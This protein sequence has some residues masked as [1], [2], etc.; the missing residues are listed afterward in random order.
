MLQDDFAKWIEGAAVPRKEA[1]IVAD[2]KGM[3]L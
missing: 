3:G 1:M 2:V